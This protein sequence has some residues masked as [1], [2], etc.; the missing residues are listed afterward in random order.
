MAASERPKSVRMTTYIRLTDD[1]RFGLK[2][3]GEFWRIEK[4][5]PNMI[6]ILSDPHDFDEAV[7][8]DKMRI[9]ALMPPPPEEEPEEEIF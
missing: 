3:N 7:E 4:L 9:E 2:K 1:G 8:R 5:H 6:G